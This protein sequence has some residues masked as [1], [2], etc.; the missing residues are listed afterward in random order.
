MRFVKIEKE[1]N[2]PESWKLLTRFFVKTCGNKVPSIGPGL[3]P[4][5]A[6]K[7][8]VWALHRAR[9]DLKS[10]ALPPDALAQLPSAIIRKVLPDLRCTSPASAT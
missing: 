7:D 10:A 5:Q 4:P 6:V 8:P 3:L 9:V 1:F 2:R